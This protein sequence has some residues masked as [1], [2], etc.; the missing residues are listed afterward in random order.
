MLQE[1]AQTQEIDTYW[2]QWSGQK[3]ER[4]TRSSRIS[5]MRKCGRRWVRPFFVPRPLHRRSTYALAVQAHIKAGSRQFPSEASP[6]QNGPG[7]L[8][9]ADRQRNEP[10]S[11]LAMPS[12]P[13]GDSLNNERGN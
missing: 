6:M 12:R 7:S 5:A 9:R 4:E 2:Q 11:P 1:A 10:S 3:D 13:L 8:S